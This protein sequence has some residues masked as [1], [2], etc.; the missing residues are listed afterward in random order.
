MSEHS[1]LREA[2]VQQVLDELWSA[3]LIPFSLT[4]GEVTEDADGY[5]IYFNDSRMRTAC[6]LLNPTSSFM[7]L[8]RA[9]VLAR[10]AKIS[11]P[12]KNWHAAQAG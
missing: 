9:A 5:T 6:V 11:G 12:L 3:E 10:V 8:V 1:L 2:E 4:V 7:D